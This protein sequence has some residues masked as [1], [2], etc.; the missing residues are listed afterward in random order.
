[1]DKSELLF[2]VAKLLRQYTKAKGQYSN[3]Q[4]IDKNKPTIIYS[5][6]RFAGEGTKMYAWDSDV[7]VNVND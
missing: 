7:F 6:I 5:G 4:D 3:T 2:K 1:M